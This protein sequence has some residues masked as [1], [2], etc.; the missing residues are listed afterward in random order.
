LL[1]VN[2]STQ[3]ER[4][5]PTID[6]LH[7]AGYEDVRGVAGAVL[8]TQTAIYMLGEPLRSAAERLAD[9]IDLPHDRIGLFSDGPPVA[10]RG[11]AQLILYLGGG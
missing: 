8:T 11:D 9:D 5:T 1:V 2:G 6:L 4:L 3:G 10:A 7:L